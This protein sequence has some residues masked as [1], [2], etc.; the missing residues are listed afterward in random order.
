MCSLTWLRRGEGYELFFN[1]DESLERLP[2]RPPTRRQRRGVELLAPLDAD[3]GGTWLGVNAFGLSVGLLNGDPRGPAPVDPISRGLLVLELLEARE[4]AE[5]ARRIRALDLG[6]WRPFQLFALEPRAPFLGARWDGARLVVERR[7]GASGLLSSSALVPVEAERNRRRVLDG[8]LAGRGEPD[9]DLLLAFHASHDPAPSGVSVCMH[10]PDA[11][12]VSFTR[13]R[14]GDD[15][16]ALGYS[17]AAPCRR[18]PLEWLELARA[19]LSDPG[20]AGA[21]DRASP[22]T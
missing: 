6:R 18:V 9:E 22:G 20:A 7:P 14:V 12:T 19:P 15:A 8:L 17:P 4:G 13:V 1:R 21:Q 5:V 3:A 16:V 11:Q 10:R 2:A